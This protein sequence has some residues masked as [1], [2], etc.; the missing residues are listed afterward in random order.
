MP[1]R[2]TQNDQRQQMG[3]IP[4]QLDRVQRQ[5]GEIYDTPETLDV[6]Q[7]GQT[8]FSQNAR[9]AFDTGP[10]MALELLNAMGKTSEIFNE[11]NKAKDKGDREVAEDLQIASDKI[12]ANPDFDEKA[13]LTRINA[14]YSMAKPLTKRFEAVFSNQAA[15]AQA[16]INALND[17]DFLMDWVIKTEKETLGYPVVSTNPDIPS[18]AEFREEA[19]SDAIKRFPRLGSQISNWQKGTELKSLKD[20]FKVISDF[21]VMNATMALNEMAAANPDYF[22]GPEGGVRS[23]TLGVILDRAAENG[24]PA[25][26]ITD[27]PAIMQNLDALVKNKTIEVQQI[28]TLKSNIGTAQASQ[29]NMFNGVM[30][31]TD[32]AGTS[33]LSPSQMFAAWSNGRK[34][35]PALAPGQLAENLYTISTGI[36]NIRNMQFD[37]KGSDGMLT[38]IMSY[39]PL[40][41]QGKNVQNLVKK[42]K[43]DPSL[44]DVQFRAENSA[45][46]QQTLE[47]TSNL[48]QNDFRRSLSPAEAEALTLKIGSVQS[49]LDRP[50]RP[51][52]SNDL[53]D[54]RETY[55]ELALTTANPDDN[56]MQTMNN[57]STL[58]QAEI[59]TRLKEDK[60]GNVT[61]VETKE[62]IDLQ[63]KAN[64]S[65]TETPTEEEKKARL[66]LNSDP[67]FKSKYSTAT[68][69][70]DD[71]AS[72][73]KI[74]GNLNTGVDLTTDPLGGD[75]AIALDL[76]AQR[77]EPK[78]VYNPLQEFFE[79]KDINKEMWN[80]FWKAPKDSYDSTAVTAPIQ[81]T[82][83]DL[84]NLLLDYPQE[85]QFRDIVDEYNNSDPNT[86]RES[87]FLREFDDLITKLDDPKADDELSPLVSQLKGIRR[88]MIKTISQNIANSSSLFTI[89]PDTSKLTLSKDNNVVLPFL[90]A[91]TG[92]QVA[93]AGRVNGD[94]AS[95]IVTRMEQVTDELKNVKPEER[96]Q[97]FT[98][99]QRTVATLQ[100]LS[101]LN[102]S[103]LMADQSVRRSVWK[104]TGAML[105]LND[106]TVKILSDS[107]SPRDMAISGG[108]QDSLEWILTEGQTES[109]SQN[110]GNYI[111][112]VTNFV[113]NLG[114]TGVVS[115]ITPTPMVD[116]TN[117]LVRTVDPSQRSGPI[118]RN[119]LRQFS[120]VT[121]WA[122]EE[123]HQVDPVVTQLGGS[124]DNLNEAELKE[125]QAVHLDTYYDVLSSYSNGNLLNKAI[126]SGELSTA[127]QNGL[128]AS[129][130]DQRDAPSPTADFITKQA[131][132]EGVGVVMAALPTDIED[133]T[134]TS[135]VPTPM[136]DGTEANNNLMGIPLRLAPYKPGA[137]LPP[138]ATNIKVNNHYWNRINTTLTDSTNGTITRQQVNQASILGSVNAA[139]NTQESLLQ[140]TNEWK[141]LN[142]ESLPR[143]TITRL[144]R[145]LD[146]T[147]YER[148]D[149]VIPVTQIKTTR[150]DT[151]PTMFDKQVGVSYEDGPSMLG[152]HTS[153]AVLS[154]LEHAY[155]TQSP[156]DF[157]ATIRDVEKRLE[158]P[159][160]A[161]GNKMMGYSSY[162]QQNG[163]YEFYLFGVSG[164]EQNRIIKQSN[165][166]FGPMEYV[167]YATDRGIRS[168][169]NFTQEQVG[170]GS[171]WGRTSRSP[172]EFD[173]KK[174]SMTTQY[175]TKAE[176]I[177]GR[178]LK[179]VKTTV[180]TAIVDAKDRDPNKNYPFPTPDLPPNTQ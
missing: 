156:D 129:N 62:L 8:Q 72:N 118:M 66:I 115:E 80:E 67:R 23:T 69:M 75:F 178:N 93:A 163:E 42:L 63:K 162:N 85:T 77:F 155:A 152:L 81:S 43:E 83:R 102:N 127:V 48:Y 100:T 15:G 134:V 76:I 74:M 165:E 110:I 133:T 125:F 175:A 124:V 46:I 53:P 5:T 146:K 171:S 143:E 39:H 56:A 174:G 98:D 137:G 89:D 12:I 18:Q 22:T 170:E 179:E 107:T 122:D 34:I 41:Y 145:I 7:Q 2:P 90:L 35:N 88:N 20:Q 73:A 96:E 168:F 157:S 101:S 147:L 151:S 106:T 3:R 59:K 64:W 140:R 135:A 116:L 87:H 180:N 32:A 54:V 177:Q 153:A 169:R 21:T 49:M 138:T 17:E 33:D 113:S 130:T 30:P 142:D 14:I 114:D 86:D 25:N 60:K 112:R 104:F 31:F 70:N 28:E 172:F 111:T 149:G 1:P 167:D 11:I 154:Y 139:S 4:G 92:N 45:L 158:Q 103:P 27:S 36:D 47:Q 58:V 164:Q 13:K 78:D 50:V 123:V 82:V 117:P 99:N 40:Q 38:A 94:S 131:Q 105:N 160:T 44:L 136:I 150:G 119:V 161:E 95:L 29:E 6:S 128:L 37:V 61:S 52:S 26:L 109:G 166:T 57:I 176:E 97:W 121:P 10:N 126:K 148:G 159:E 16:K 144:D 173:V 9:S 91:D 65:S 55:I 24:I 132:T 71:I 51:P 108:L 120:Q 141:S 79:G 68:E 19:A 84:D